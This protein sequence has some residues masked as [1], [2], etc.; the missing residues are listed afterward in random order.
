MK[1]HPSLHPLSEHHHHALVQA[2][3]IRRAADVPEAE[4]SAALEKAGRALL[5]HWKATG[6][7]HFQEEE[8]ILLPAF[9]RHTELNED[10]TVMKMLAQHTQIR[11]QMEQLETLLSTKQPVDFDVDAEVVALGAL[12]HEHVRLEEDELFPRIE[13]VLGEDEMD[14][15]GQR[16]TRLHGEQERP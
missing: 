15:I 5:D 7:K 12:L 3:G 10:P 13:D 11:A 14:A 8:D 9:S 16:F 2:L 6:R 1:R 4:R